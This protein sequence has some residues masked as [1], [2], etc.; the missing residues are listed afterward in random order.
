[1]KKI[2]TKVV[3]SN[4][5]HHQIP[6]D[7]REQ[8]MK[9]QII[10]RITKK[11]IDDNLVS[12]TE[13]KEFESVNYETSFLIIQEEDYHN[14]INEINKLKQTIGRINSVYVFTL[15]RHIKQIERFLKIKQ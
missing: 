11:I 9:S 4:E 6:A 10:Q 2:F 12:I 13:T 3:M 14:L 1:M 8:E 5:S 15:E 7:I